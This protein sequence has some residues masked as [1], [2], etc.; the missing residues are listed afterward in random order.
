MNSSWG[1]TYF[2]RER[3]KLYKSGNLPG[4]GRVF[5]PG[6][7]G[8]NFLLF[9]F[10]S[11]FSSCLRLFSLFL[12]TKWFHHHQ[13][14]ARPRCSV[15]R[16][17]RTVLIFLTKS[18]M[19]RHYGKWPS[20]GG[21]YQRTPCQRPFSVRCPA[22]GAACW[23]L[24]GARSRQACT[25]GACEAFCSVPIFTS[26]YFLNI[27]TSSDRRVSYCYAYTRDV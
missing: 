20:T 17:P 21:R 14:E 15:H 16:T 27:F 24:N 26:S 9:I 8:E 2:L 1:E 3:G 5:Y 25:T 12:S 11:S 18:G 10:C 13:V 4:F 6:F 7:E 23:C 19:V 22:V